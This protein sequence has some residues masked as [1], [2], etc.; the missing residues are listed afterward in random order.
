MVVQER[1]HRKLSEAF[2]PIYLDIQNESYKHS[3][4]PGSESHFRVVV[5]SGEFERKT[6]VQQHQMVNQVL[7]EELAGPVHALSIQ[8]KT[9]EQW[10]SSGKAIR[11]TP[12]CLGGSKA[13]SLS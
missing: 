10:E 13:D 5:V 12:P 1:I 8:A 7:Q 4:A 9:P 11:K 3:V 2:N 6:R